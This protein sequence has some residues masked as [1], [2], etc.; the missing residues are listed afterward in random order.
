MFRLLLKFL[1]IIHRLFTGLFR[2][3]KN[4]WWQLVSEGQLLMNNVDFELGKI[5]FDGRSLLRFEKDSKV[6]IGKFFTIRSGID[7]DTIGNRSHSIIFVKNGATLKIGDYSGI[8]NTAIYC[9][10]SI[11]IG[12]HV[13]IGAGTQI[14]DTD[15]HS[16]SWKDRLDKTDLTKRKMKP[17]QIDDLVFIGADSLILKGVHIGEKS[18]IGAGSVV[19]QDIPSCE[20]WAG[21]PAVFIKRINN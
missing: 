10:C 20:I 17:V 21:N 7:S 5:R 3:V 4:Y 2:R 12:N 13:N 11:K 1:Y 18:I 8:S 15:F 16:L 6:S 9:H 19:T 14:F